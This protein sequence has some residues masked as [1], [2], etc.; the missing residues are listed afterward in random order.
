MIKL[1]DNNVVE[2]GDRVLI[3]SD[4]QSR[5]KTGIIKYFYEVAQSGYV[6]KYAVVILDKNKKEIG[7]NIRSLEKTI[8]KQEGEEFIMNEKF[9]DCVGYVGVKFLDGYNNKEYTYASYEEDFKVGEL[10][11]VKANGQFK[12][13]EAKS[14]Y[15]KEDFDGSNITAEIVCKIYTTKYNQ[16]CEERAKKQ[17]LKEKMD[18]KVKELQNL[19]IYEMLAKEDKELAELLKEFKGI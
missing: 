2:I 15:G 19:A 9:K 16:R 18:K 3:I 7:Y 10:A 5:G 4:C 14:V 12:V 1:S 17:V 11:I 13:V 6:K 8:Y